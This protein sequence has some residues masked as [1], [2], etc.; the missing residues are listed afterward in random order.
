MGWREEATLIPVNA[1]RQCASCK[2][3]ILRSLRCKAY[4]NRIPEE[5]LGGEVDHRWPYK[6]DNGILYDP[7]DPEHPQTAPYAKH[8]EK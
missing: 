2:N 7:V 8:T 1:A 4:P 6:G 3:Y 5:I